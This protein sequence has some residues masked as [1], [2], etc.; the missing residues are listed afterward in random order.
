M[1]R[2]GDIAK[3]LGFSRDVLL[4]KLQILEI[5]L[6]DKQ[7]VEACLKEYDHLNEL[8]TAHDGDDE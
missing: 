8:D 6:S 1:E 4:K 3:K 2:L 5:I 7:F